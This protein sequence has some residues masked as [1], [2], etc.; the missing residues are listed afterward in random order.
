MRGSRFFLNLKSFSDLK[1][2]FLTHRK[3]F[4]L[5]KEK[6]EVLVISIET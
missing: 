5:K 2:T 1:C 3:E 4:T 6:R